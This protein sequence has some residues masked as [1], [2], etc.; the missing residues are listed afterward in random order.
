[1][2]VKRVVIDSSVALKWELR[3]EETL[4]Q[5]DALLEDVLAGRP[6]PVVPTLFDDVAT[7]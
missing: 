3:D 4:P 7:S 6:S 1:M 5:A 2:T